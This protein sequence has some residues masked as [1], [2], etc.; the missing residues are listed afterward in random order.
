MCWRERSVFK[1]LRQWAKSAITYV[2]AQDYVASTSGPERKSRL[3]AMN[4]S[5]RSD[6]GVILFRKIWER[7]LRALKGKRPLKKWTYCV[8]EV[9]GGASIPSW[10]LTCHNFGGSIWLY[11]FEIGKIDWLGAALNA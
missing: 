5:G 10:S 3:E 2:N 8:G 9:A 7:E 11:V 6:L 4:T 1:T